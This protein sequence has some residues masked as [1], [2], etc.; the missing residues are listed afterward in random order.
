MGSVCLIDSKTTPD[1]IRL[2][3]RQ[4]KPRAFI[5]FVG[6]HGRQHRLHVIAVFLVEGVDGPLLSF[7][8]FVFERIAEQVRVAFAVK[9]R[10]FGKAQ[11]ISI[12]SFNA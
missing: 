9:T 5:P 4:P 11:K 8:V 10:G 2:K 1:R 12:P 3:H 7:P 6:S